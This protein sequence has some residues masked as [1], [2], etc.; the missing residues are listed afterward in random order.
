M[1]KRNY[2]WAII[3]FLI[4]FMIFILVPA[5]MLDFDIHREKLAAL[6]TKNKIVYI[7]RMFSRPSRSELEAL[8]NKVEKLEKELSS[9]K[10]QTN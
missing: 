2:T 6:N 9:L 7:L 5:M 1:E 10:S 8:Q 4:I 3:F